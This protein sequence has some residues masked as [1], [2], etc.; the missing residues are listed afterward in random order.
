MACQLSNRL[1]STIG[2][3]PFSSHSHSKP[4]SCAL[5]KER[6]EI[7]GNGNSYIVEDFQL[8]RYLE[9]SLDKSKIFNEGKGHKE[10]VTKFLSYVRDEIPNPFTWLELKSTSLAG[11]YAQKYLNSGKQHG[12]FS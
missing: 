12:I 6:V 10:S 2:W 11:I 1:L 3:L 5:A 8:L 7:H 9:G 4:W